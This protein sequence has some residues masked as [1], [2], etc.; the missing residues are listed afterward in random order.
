[1]LLLWWEELN[2]IIANT[3][4]GGDA[5]VVEAI[6]VDVGN[7]VEPAVKRARSNGTALISGRPTPAPYVG[8]GL[9]LLYP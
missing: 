3:V 2:G 4:L 6:G 5:P 1:M 9:N 7:T 8:L